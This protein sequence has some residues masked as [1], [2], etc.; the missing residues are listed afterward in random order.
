MDLHTQFNVI[1]LSMSAIQISNIKVESDGWNVQVCAVSLSLSVSK[2]LIFRY[3]SFN[4]KVI[5]EERLGHF[6]YPF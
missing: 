5:E 1:L 4:Q 3:C 6:E 2:P